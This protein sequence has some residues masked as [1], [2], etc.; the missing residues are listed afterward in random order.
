MDSQ[1][2]RVK[3]HREEL[4]SLLNLKSKLDHEEAVSSYAE[5]YQNLGWVLQAVNP[6]DG[7]DLEMDSGENHETWVSRLWEPGLS[8]PKISLGVRT[9]KRSRVL[10]LEVAKGQGESILDQYGE[11]R[12]GCTAVLGAGREQHFYAWDPSPLFDSVSCLRDG[13]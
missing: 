6:Q 9:G 12:A 5:K 1:D 13:L 7:T 3:I 11:W 4:E 10:V 8:G 2:R